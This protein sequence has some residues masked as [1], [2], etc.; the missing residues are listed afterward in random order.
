MYKRQAFKIIETAVAAMNL[1]KSLEE[2]SIDGDYLEEIRRDN[3][4]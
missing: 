1:M 2:A 4:F 3:L